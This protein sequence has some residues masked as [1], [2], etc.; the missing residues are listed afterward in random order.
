MLAALSE[1]E[2][3]GDDSDEGRR[4]EL[5]DELV[6][7]FAESTEAREL[8]DVHWC[9]TIMDLAASHLGVTIASVGA[10]ELREFLF[11][12]VPRKVSVAASAAG[13]IVAE[14][15]A[16]FAFLKREL[17]LRES[18]ACLRLLGTGPGTAK[19]LEVALSDP[20]HFGMA[21]SMMMAGADAGFDMSSKEGVEAWMREYPGEATAIVDSAAA[22]RYRAPSRGPEGCAREAKSAQGR[23]Q[24]AQ[25]EPVGRGTNVSHARCSPPR[26][27]RSARPPRQPVAGALPGMHEREHVDRRADR[28]ADEHEDDQVREAGNRVRAA[29]VVCVAEDREAQWGLEHVTNAL[30]HLR[31]ELLARPGRAS[32]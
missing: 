16:F 7:R 2:A 13:E 4:A 19:K 21:K 1:L 14:C 26:A 5:E 32:S 11:E 23:A 6:R 12:L 29:H 24:G 3:D 10:P 15:R 17:S 27:R 28:I 25:E 30:A 8:D 18:D 31:H 22:G 9:R 20:R